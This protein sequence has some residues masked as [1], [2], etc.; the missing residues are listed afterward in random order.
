VGGIGVNGA[1]RHIASSQGFYIQTNGASPVLNISE[2][3]KS[4]ANAVLIKDEDPANTL[5]L[6]I[7]SDDKTDE[8]V[9]HLNS[10]ATKA[11]DG[12]YDAFKF[13]NSNS[14]NPTI[15]SIAAN[16]DLS[17]NSLPF[18][19]DSMKV[20]VRVTVGSS[21]MYHISW[22]GMN[23]FPLGTC[24]VIEDLKNGNKSL[25]SKDGVYYFT[26]DAGF[27][28]PRFLI[29]ITTPVTYKSTDITCSNIND[30]SVMVEN[31][32]VSARKV[33][34][35]D[36]S[37]NFVQEAI[38][39]SNSNFT[40]TQL[41]S[42]NYLLVSPSTSICGDFTQMIEILPA[43]SIAAK[44]EVS[45]QVLEVNEKVLLTTS[46]DKGNNLSWNL[47]DG[48]M[49]EGENSI[50]YQYQSEGEYT[51]TLT[52]T[53]GAC[54]QTE[55]KVLTVKNVQVTDRLMDVQQVN[56]EFYAVFRF[57]DITTV[58]IRLTNALGQEVTETLQFEGKNGR[59]RLPIENTAVGV[60]MVVLN[61]GKD[62]ITKK[63]V[64]K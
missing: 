33:I 32:A 44:F 5:R 40:F 41:A 54:A 49:I 13:F 21:G 52:N 7:H 39:A 26:E 24:F 16:K 1:T 22:S 50:A 58:N 4:S 17:I 8:M 12:N 56:D 6:K 48:N 37:G 15:S 18:G 42:G 19:G 47:G 59:V 38:V 2:N 27:K 28:S 34:L 61:T 57:E 23:K 45:K 55:S 10:N 30:G 20:P 64:K 62:T 25:L 11:F 35:K 36:L 60:Y 9:I 51:V 63:I 29:H 43:A 46:Q 31:N 3:A 53:K 14:T